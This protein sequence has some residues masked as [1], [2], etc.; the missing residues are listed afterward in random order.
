MM[1]RLMLIALTLAATG[2]LSPFS[3]A[4]CRD[5][6]GLVGRRGHYRDSTDHAPP[7]KGVRCGIAAA[8]TPR[9]SPH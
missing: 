9:L 7:L 8:T 6:N 2:C 1:K 3:A 5:R 4:A